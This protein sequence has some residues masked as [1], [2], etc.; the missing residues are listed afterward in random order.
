MAHQT[1]PRH[2]NAAR[3]RHVLRPRLD[4]LEGRLLLSAG[5]LD[6]TFGTGGFA[7]EGFTKKGVK[8]TRGDA[9][10]VEIQGDGSIVA[11][12]NAFGDFGLMRLL[13]DGSLDPSFGSGGKVTTAFS[14]NME[15]V[16]DLAI[17]PTDGKIVAVGLSDQR[18]RSRDPYNYDF[19]L[20]RY[21][22]DGTL[23]TSFGPSRNG[24]VTTGISTAATGNLNNL[25]DHP[26]AVAIQPDGKILVAGSTYNGVDNDFALVRYNANGTLDTSFGPD[27]SGIVTTDFAPG[28][29]DGI[30][31][32]MA[33]ADGK[34]LVAGDSG[35]SSALARY[36]SDGTLDDG[37][38]IDTT[39]GDAFGTGGK[40]ITTIGPSP[41]FVEGLAIQSD[42]KIIAAGAA[43]GAG[44]DFAVV[45]Y[46]TDGALD[47]S[48]GTGGIT[49]VTRPDGQGTEP[50][51][52]VLQADGK[53]V[54]AGSTGP[55][56]AKRVIL[57]RL[58]SS[59]QL[60]TSF[61]SAGFSVPS[62]GTT[63]EYARAIALQPDGKVVTA[64]SAELA[65]GSHKFAVAR[66]LTDAPAA[67]LTA[68]A[69]GVE[70]TALTGGGSL[71][72]DPAQTRATVP[73]TAVLDRAIAEVAV[74]PPPTDPSDPSSIF[75]RPARRRP[76]AQNR[77]MLR[78]AID[79]GL[80]LATR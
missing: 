57:A 53:I 77:I 74:A 4:P 19:A 24:K 58:D 36:N 41:S 16:I 31:D 25:W 35:G 80:D 63:S 48:F 34:I 32:M 37:T 20:A 61:G 39:P 38:A 43:Y 27:H 3:P 8:T 60:D 66:F 59:G 75:P 71:L 29:G 64:G 28:S 51:G 69:S 79:P 15:Y 72:A 40:V 44:V 46:H 50:G 76:N 55:H 6:P 26:H 52:V 5:D 9:L 2:S 70:S 10:A 14:T 42:G 17:Q 12:G 11:A 62:F 45:R 49:T 47:V 68:T 21:N 73:P 30:V 1:R 22:L 65:D 67:T 56:G 23:D 7:L 78:L 54:V 33:L 13:P 18:A